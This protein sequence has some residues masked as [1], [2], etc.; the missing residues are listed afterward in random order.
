LDL[1]IIW[2]RHYRYVHYRCID[3]YVVNRCVDIPLFLPDPVWCFHRM[4]KPHKHTGYVY[5]QGYQ[6]KTGTYYL[7]HTVHAWEQF[8]AE[9]SWM[10]WSSDKGKKGWHLQ[11]MPSAMKW[12]PDTQETPTEYKI[13][14]RQNTLK[15][16]T[17]KFQILDF[18]WQGVL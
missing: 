15:M 18:K 9:P 16:M 11:R 1:S 5:R 3:F 7:L 12:A 14:S 13:F 6:D 17:E 4:L 8:C 2:W 10:Q